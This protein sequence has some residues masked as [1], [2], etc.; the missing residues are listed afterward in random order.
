M[1]NAAVVGLGWWGCYI[2]NSLSVSEKITLTRA[3]DLNLDADADL[4]AKYPGTQFSADLQDALDDPA[5][6]F[7][8]LATPHSMHEDQVKRV[9]AAGKH[10]FCEKPLCLTADSAA[11]AIQA[12]EEA[13]VQ[14]GVGHERRFEPAMLEID[15][16]IK[17]GELGTIMHAESN[18]SHD[19]LA[20]VPA[21]D[22]RTGAKDAPAAGMTGMGIH[23]TDAYVNML[24]PVDEVF[25]MTAK[26]V[27]D[28][29]HGD[30]VG[31]QLRM[32]SGA[33][34]Y[35]NAILKTPL[36]L[37]YQVFGSDAWV[38]ARNPTHPDTPGVTYLTVYKAG[39]EP[40]TREYAWVDA[41][42][43][44]FE[45]FA[46]VITG[47]APYPNTNAQKLQNIQTFEAICISAL[48]NRPVKVG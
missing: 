20:N 37:R 15:R 2:L 10:V 27:L 18:F 46:D 33:T 22:W 43:A 28:W 41:V 8:I 9:A 12:C 17:S 42:R 31:V 23:L 11:R 44:N 29:E 7:V 38:E 40:E 47:A 16:M 19:K 45:A 21:G 6:D 3:H 39:G 4:I 48:E 14:L 35:L 30:V 24:G 25:A 13:G 34:A 26:R 5:I 36:F 32:K 1:L